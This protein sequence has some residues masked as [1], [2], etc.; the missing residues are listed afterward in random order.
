[1]DSLETWLTMAPTP[2]PIHHGT[3]IVDLNLAPG[4][5]SISPAKDKEQP[6]GPGEHC[7]DILGPRPQDINKGMFPCLNPPLSF[8]MMMLFLPVVVR[9]HFLKWNFQ[10]LM[11]ILLGFL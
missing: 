10:S 6:M 8:R 3:R 1:M 7:G 2:A 11:A 9:H 4:S 5:S